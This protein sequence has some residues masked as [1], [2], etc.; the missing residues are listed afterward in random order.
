VHVV[1]R[2]KGLKRRGEGTKGRPII[3]LD[4]SELEARKKKDKIGELE[5]QICIRKRKSF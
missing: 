3:Y 5:N 4:L 1:M 2:E